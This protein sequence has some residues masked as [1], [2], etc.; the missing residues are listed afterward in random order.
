M[1]DWRE[2]YEPRIRIVDGYEYF[3]TPFH[4]DRIEV[5]GRGVMSPLEVKDAP[6]WRP[7]DDVAKVS[8]T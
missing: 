2:W 5:Q 6:M 7:A 3:D 4:H 1:S 8:S